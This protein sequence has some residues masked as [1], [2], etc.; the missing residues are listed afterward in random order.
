[1]LATPNF[2]FTQFEGNDIPT[3]LGQTGWNGNFSKLDTEMAKIKSTADTASADTVINKNA[4]EA[5]NEIVSS[6]QAGSSAAEQDIT[7]LK[8]NYEQIHHEVVTNKNT[9]DAFIDGQGQV[10]ERN[11]TRFDYLERRAIYIDPVTGNDNN[12]GTQDK[13]FKSFAGLLSKKVQASGI[14]LHIVNDIELSGVLQ[15]SGTLEIIEENN[16][17]IILTGDTR[18][19]CSSFVSNKDL[20]FEGSYNFLLYTSSAVFIGNVSSNGKVRIVRSTMF[21]EPG[22]T[23]TELE[24]YDSIVIANNCTVGKFTASNSLIMAINSTLN[25]VTSYNS[26]FIK[27]ATTWS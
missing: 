5:T 24:T 25:D 18:L 9:F 20:T 11:N 1:M 22:H 19:Y 17:K 7:V 27:T 8:A 15:F 16:S 4:I 3:W 21:V 26:Y 2:N 12:L 13:P 6:L 14:V 23:F 10:N